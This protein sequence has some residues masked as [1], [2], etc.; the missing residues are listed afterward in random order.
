[1]ALM[2]QLSHLW[3]SQ[4]RTVRNACRN[5][6]IKNRAPTLQNT[7]RTD[8]RRIEFLRV[9][10]LRVVMFIQQLIRIGESSTT[11][12]PLTA[13]II[14]PFQLR[15]FLHTTKK[16]KKYRGRLEEKLHRLVYSHKIQMIIT[17]KMREKKKRH[18]TLVFAR[19]EF[20]LFF[21]LLCSIFFSP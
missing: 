16:K 4:S 5:I 10:L 2:E 19:V 20:Q 15:R 21:I 9:L 11:R 8:K 17:R 3:T 13:A 18:R 6:D 7:T 14:S 12:E 1:M